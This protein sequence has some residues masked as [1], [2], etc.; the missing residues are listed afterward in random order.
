[1]LPSLIV[2]VCMTGRAEER[3]GGGGGG[4]LGHFVASP[5]ANFPSPQ[6]TKVIKSKMAA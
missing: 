4:R 6:P 1:M 5:S 3:M 2:I